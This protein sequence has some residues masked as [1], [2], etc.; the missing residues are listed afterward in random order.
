MELV[1]AEVLLPFFFAASGM[2]TSLSSLNDKF[3]DDITVPFFFV[4]DKLAKFLPGCFVT[5]IV[6]RR[7]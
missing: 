3:Y 7:P 1:T 2:Q 4:I 5:K 6:T